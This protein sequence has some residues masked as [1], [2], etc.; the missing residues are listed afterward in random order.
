MSDW[1]IRLSGHRVFE[2]I[3]RPL[4]RAKLGDNYRLASAAFIWAVIRRLYAAR[5]SG[6]KTEMFGYVSGGY[7]QILARFEADL[8]G[9]GV[10]LNL[11]CQV[12]QIERSGSEVRVTTA[13]GERVFDQV[14]VTPLA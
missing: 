10:E 8:R 9:R 14:V 3:W 2:R 4:L 12:Q 13:T 11:G 6:L 1:L 5:R 7:A